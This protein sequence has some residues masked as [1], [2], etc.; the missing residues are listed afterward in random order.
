MTK[1]I[2]N[3]KEFVLE[4][5]NL[6]DL[7]DSLMNDGHLNDVGYLVLA[8]DG[9]DYTKSFW[10]T[11]DVAFD[12]SIL[13]CNTEAEDEKDTIIYQSSS[14]GNMVYEFCTVDA[15]GCK[16]D[17]DWSHCNYGI[18]DC[19]G[20]RGRFYSRSEAIKLCKEWNEELGW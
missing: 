17:C 13:D 7:I 19:S 3:W 10:Q 8:Q 14:L 4:G 11:Y 5:V 20:A 16:Q 6:E 15:E 18:N 1:I 9:E 2:K 12:D